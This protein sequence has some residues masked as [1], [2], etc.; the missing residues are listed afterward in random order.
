MIDVL[1]SPPRGLREA[2]LDPR[3]G[4]DRRSIVDAT[5]MSPSFIERMVLRAQ[6]WSLRGSFRDLV[7]P[8]DLPLDEVVLRI[9][10]AHESPTELRLAATW[11][12]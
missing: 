10:A 8:L 9:A 1:C 6:A 3:L 5:R 7:E 11:L 4:P 2:I 12:T